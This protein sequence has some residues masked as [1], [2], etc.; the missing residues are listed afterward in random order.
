VCPFICC[1]PH[2][3]FEEVHVFRR[4]AHGFPVE[5]TFEEEGAAGVAGA[6]E[7]GFEFTLEAFVLFAREV[8]VAGGVDEGFILSSH[9]GSTTPNHV[10]S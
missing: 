6:L 1:A 4:E 9:G 5:A 10:L 2:R 8:A 3:R 7:T